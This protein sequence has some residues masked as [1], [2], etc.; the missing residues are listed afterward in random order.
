MPYLVNAG[1]PWRMGRLTVQPVRQRAQLGDFWDFMSKPRFATPAEGALH[2]AVAL[3]QSQVRARGNVPTRMPKGPNTGKLAERYTDAQG[4]Y[5]YALA[6]A[7][8][9]AADGRGQ[10]VLD[11]QVAAG[12]AVQRVE[13]VIKRDWSP[14]LD[15][16]AKQALNA[17]RAIV[18]E[19]LGI[20]PWL[21]TVAVLGAGALAVRTLVPSLPSF[22]SFT[23]GRRR[24]R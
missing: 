8:A 21:V 4:V 18:G 20:P 16:A 17:P 24:R 14:E 10:A 9:L 5:R 13:D 6:S 19:V 1:P 2:P 7:A 3:W 11:N 12:A 15:A 22:P 23:R